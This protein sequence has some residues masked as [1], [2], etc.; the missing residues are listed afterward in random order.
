VHLLKTSIARLIVCIPLALLASCAESARSDT[1]AGGT[2]TVVSVLDGDTFE[3]VQGDTSERVRLIGVNTP[4]QSECFGAEASAWLASRILQQQ[5]NLEGD[6][7]DRDQYG[8]LLRYV[9][10]DGVDVNL[11][12]LRNGL[13]IAQR[14]PPD[15][16]RSEAFDRAEAEAEAGETGLWAPDACGEATQGLI[17][18]GTVHV[19]I[20][21]IRFDADGNDAENLN[22]EWVELENLSGADLRLTGWRL[23]DESTRN[24]FEFPQ[25]FVLHAG[26]RVRVRSGCGL[27]SQVFLHWCAS[28]SAIWN[29]SGDTV[30]VLDAHGNI[31]TSRR[32]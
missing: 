12:L 24:R 23:R 3:V 8:R 15:T 25:D 1:D 9:A 11:E 10:I 20:V 18:D 29:N 7:S 17:A 5:V 27:D 16:A 28:G 4:E 22:D 6:R 2:W 19:E 30:F 13:G 31:V 26:Q 14:F 32:Y 21:E